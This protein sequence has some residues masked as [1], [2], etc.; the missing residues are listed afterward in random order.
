MRVAEGQSAPGEVLA[1][2]RRLRV[3]EAAWWQKALFSAV[4]A[5]L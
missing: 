2:L 5:S 1:C 3:L 4:A